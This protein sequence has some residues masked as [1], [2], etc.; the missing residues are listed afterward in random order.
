ICVVAA[1]PGTPSSPI[2]EKR[3]THT[4]IPKRSVIG[5]ENDPHGEFF[6]VGSL[7]RVRPKQTPPIPKQPPDPQTQVA[8]LVARQF[9]SSQN[10]RQCHTMGPFTPRNL[11]PPS[12]QTSYRIKPGKSS[13]RILVETRKESNGGQVEAIKETLSESARPISR[14]ESEVLDS[15]RD[16]SVWEGLTDENAGTAYALKKRKGRG[17]LDSICWAL[18][19]RTNAGR[20]AEKGKE[21]AEKALE[22]GQRPRD[23]SGSER[24]GVKLTIDTR[25]LPVDTSHSATDTPS[26]SV[27][28]P[29]AEAPTTAAESTTDNETITSGT[30]KTKWKWTIGRKRTKS[31]GLPSPPPLSDQAMGER[32][33]SASILF[34][35]P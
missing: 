12:R 7:G 10:D 29:V 35:P 20:K 9:V 28:S 18:G 26:T 19:D 13:K 2:I 30:E 11:S 32:C 21:K 3:R 5:K 4:L 8:D 27:L 34:W 15:L 31:P 25:A 17:T 14:I 24:P 22:M 1:T 16:A 6:P 23:G 33:H